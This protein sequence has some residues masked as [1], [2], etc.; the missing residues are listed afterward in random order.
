MGGLGLAVGLPSAIMVPQTGREEALMSRGLKIAAGVFALL[1]ILVI[2]IFYVGSSIDSIVEKGIE[3]Y[4]SQILKARVEI[5][6]VEISPQS[7]KGSLRGV[8]IGNPEGFKTKSAF[9]LDEV[10]ITLDLESVMGNPV[11]IKEIQVVTPR[12]TY[13]LNDQGVSNLDALQRNVEA[14]TGAKSGAKSGGE[15]KKTETR[16]DAAAEGGR[17]L[18]IEKLSIQKGTIHVQAPVLE[19]DMDVPLPPIEFKNIG[20]EGSGTSPD[21]VAAKILDTVTRQVVTATAGLGL[22]ELRGIAE[23]GLGGVGDVLEEGAKGIGKAIEGIF[24]E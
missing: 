12:L 2:V 1:A 7:G 15:A 6:G 24:G 20:K 21:K 5:G 22:D 4:G 14:F 10:T 9:E 11:I 3:K 18:V 16:S 17:N 8:F 19:K 23:E 13:E